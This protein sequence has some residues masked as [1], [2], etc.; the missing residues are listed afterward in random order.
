[1]GMNFCARAYT[2]FLPLAL[3]FL[4]F[5]PPFVVISLTHSF[6]TLRHSFTVVVV[7]VVFVQRA[8]SLHTTV[9]QHVWIRINFRSY[10]PR[11]NAP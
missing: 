9:R 11:A 6:L 7:V 2:L 4:F 3:G 1:M 10:F 8:V 5:L